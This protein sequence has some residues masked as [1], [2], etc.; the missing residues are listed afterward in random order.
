MSAT[1]RVRGGKRLRRTLRKAGVDL[2]RLKAANK[3]AAE[4][5]KSAAVAATPVGGPYK[6]A[7]RGRPRTGGRL[8]ATVRSFASQRSGQIR[9]GNASRVPY[10]A[11]VHWG[12]PRTKGVQGSGIRPN[13]WMSTAAKA[14]EPA[15]L[16]EYER[17]VD[18]IIDSV[19]GA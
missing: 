6:K 17:H 13:P 12:W 5:A 4:I 10:A 1:L 14:T 2:K 18:A 16:K 15:W 11:P 7:G 19:K 8:K 9:A 3:A